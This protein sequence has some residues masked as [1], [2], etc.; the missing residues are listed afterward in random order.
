MAREAEEAAYLQVI[1]LHTSNAE[2]LSGLESLVGA[3]IDRTHC[4]K[5][6]NTLAERQTSDDRNVN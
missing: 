1:G 4:A 6:P 3:A 2:A 5:L